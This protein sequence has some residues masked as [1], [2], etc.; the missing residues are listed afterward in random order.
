MAPVDLASMSDMWCLD[1]S[2]PYVILDCLLP[3][4]II[5]QLKEFKDATLSQVKQNLWATAKE[6]PLHKR[7]K[8][9]NNYVFMCI[10]SLAVREELVDESRRLNDI[11]PF[12]PMLKVVERTGNKE[13]KLLNSQISVLIGKGLNEFDAMNSPEVNDFRHKMRRICEQV[14]EERDGKSW[15]EQ[16]LYKYPPEIYPTPEMPQYIRDKLHEKNM[17]MVTVL[18]E[19]N[20]DAKY[21]F[22]VQTCDT[23][24]TLIKQ[25]LKKRDATTG[26]A[27]D[28]VENYL[29]KICGR[30]EFLL[31][32]YPLSQYKYLQEMT[33][34]GLEHTFMLIHRENVPVE[35][36]PPKVPP[37]TNGKRRPPPPIP[38]PRKG[39]HGK[40]VSLWSM[41]E[42]FK[43]AVQSVENITWEENCKLSLRVGLYHGG[44]TICD[45]INTS[46]ELLMDGKVTWDT[47]LKF[48]IQ[49]CDV[50]RMARL[51]FALC[52]NVLDQKHTKGTTKNKKV[53][54]RNK[55]MIPISW[56]N[57]TVF[58][59]ID[60][61]RTG[62]YSLPM[63]G[64]TDDMQLEDILHPLGT[65]E[66]NPD[67]T[68][69]C[70]L[71]IKLSNFNRDLPIVYPGFEEVLAEAASH[72]RK[73]GSLLIETN[74]QAKEQLRL[75]IAKDPL[76][77]L[78]EQEKETVWSLRYECHYHF[79]ESLP[80]LLS[81]VKWNSHVDVAK[82]QALL[83]IWQ[84]LKPLAAVELLDFQY[85]DKAVRKY[86]VD[87]LKDI[88]DS[89]L[90]MYLLQVVQVLKYESYLDCD[91]VEFLLKRAL[92]NQKIG[93]IFFW[94][95]KSEMHVPSVSVRFGLILEAYCRGC[96][97]HMKMLYKQVEALSKLKEVNEL[98]KSDQYKDRKVKQ[99]ALAEMRSRFEQKS[100]F[101]S[102]KDLHSPIDPCL[103][104][105]TLK[106][107][108]CKF[109]DSKM[110]P[111]RLVWKN[112]D[113]NGDDI[114]IIF[115]N[116][117]D[118]R[119]DMLTLQII[120]IMDSI[121][122]SEGLDLRMNPYGCVATGC[123]VGMLQVVTN[124]KTI[125]NIQ[126][127]YATVTVKS[128]FNKESIYKWLS[129]CNQGEPEKLNKACQEFALSC[130]GYCVA[131]Y[132]LGIADRHSDNIMVRENGQ[133]FHIDFGHF[134]GN[135][136]S[137]YG[138]KRERVP[139]VLTND[140]VYVINKSSNKSS[141]SQD[142][143]RFKETCERAFL[144]LRKKGYLLITLF[145]TMLSTGIPEL[146]CVEDISY[147]KEALVLNLS[148]DEA[149]KHFRNKFNEALKNSWKTSLNWTA[150]NIAKDNV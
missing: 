86:A 74:D 149:I 126:K 6:Y 60:R 134:L 145:M 137:K 99:K 129:Q 89:E 9:R 124:A 1:S 147:L 139:F 31:G 90:S 53:K 91:L 104:M 120:Q 115:K 62:V 35:E 114:L 80:K 65:V 24:S 49:V 96:K 48:D 103:V 55:E 46:G 26:Q 2:N 111:L 42:G 51:C 43:A 25:V 118:L 7:L 128:A 102:L 76:E 17:F 38:S 132:V 23:P 150:H 84:K 82:M 34:K 92:N 75:M 52:Y 119:Q 8:D 138:V 79:P 140:M 83:Q 19:N 81:C 105:G 143:A 33:S 100:Y 112:Q 10:S 54:L 69:T 144:I 97:S 18:L 27:M 121:W 87:C 88:S 117:D 30:Q 44:E 64:F 148:E 4:G 68:E 3:T 109:M 122:Q 32:E 66:C 37:R 130:A 72:V 47:D 67:M 135:W 50:P 71:N 21:G 113:V 45:M 56:V 94:L 131:T 95:L 116:G 142:F 61:L 106:V 146:T 58:D 110:K 125:A 127:G 59:Y 14:G 85:A 123:K 36:K 5:V 57:I 41:N 93:H 136:K 16:M 39:D 40:S 78:C 73:T 108:Q 12:Q 22:L 11:R 63:W 28:G 101:D 15:Y 107:D 13:E 133:L 20:V 77:Q 98:I 29:L 141:Q 70:V